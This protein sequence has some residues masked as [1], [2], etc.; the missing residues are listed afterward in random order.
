MAV[1]GGISVVDIVAADTPTNLGYGP[2]D[3]WP[4]GLGIFDLSAMEWS[5]FF[6][7]SAASYVTPASVKAYIEQNGPLP[8]AWSNPTVETWF[9]GNSKWHRMT[10]GI[11]HR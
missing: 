11:I 9:T 1:V 4:Q 8:S 2:P 3:P 6:D 5:D 10:T 7:P